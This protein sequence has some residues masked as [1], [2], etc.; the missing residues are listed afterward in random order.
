ML[1]SVKE[2]RDNYNVY[3]SRILHV[4][5]HIG[6]EAPEYE[7]YFSAQIFWIEAQPDLCVSLRRRLNPNFIENIAR[8]YLI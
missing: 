6:E 1:I 5:A 7:K 2:L 4:G 3:P 8:F